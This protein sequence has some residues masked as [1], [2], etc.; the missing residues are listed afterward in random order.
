MAG[1]TIE[2]IRYKLKA[3]KI[4]RAM[5]NLNSAIKKDIQYYMVQD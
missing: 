2:K 4:V 5:P 1:V 3:D